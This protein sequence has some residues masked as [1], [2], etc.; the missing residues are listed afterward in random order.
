[1]IGGFGVSDLRDALVGVDVGGKMRR[2]DGS[3]SDAKQLESCS[4]RFDM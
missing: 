2:E 1:V 3:L 4:P